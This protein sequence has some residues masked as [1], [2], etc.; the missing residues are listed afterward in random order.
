MIVGTASIVGNSCGLGA[1]LISLVFGFSYPLICFRAWDLRAVSEM[2][3]PRSLHQSSKYFHPV[4][5]IINLSISSLKSL[6]QVLHFLNVLNNLTVNIYDNQIPNHAYYW[7]YL[8]DTFSY[9]LHM[10]WWFLNYFFTVLKLEP[11]IFC[12]K[13]DVIKIRSFGSEEFT[14]CS[15][16]VSITNLILYSAIPFKFEVLNSS[17]GML[18]K[19]VSWIL[20][21]YLTLCINPSLAIASLSMLSHIKSDRSSTLDN[22]DTSI[23][24]NASSQFDSKSS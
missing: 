9:G 24:N 2:I 13:L 23:N 16:I 15:L 14:L 10:S 22:L 18:S 7:S 11:D 1:S 19:F 21:R 12:T 6:W 4:P 8:A 20:L 17:R 5:D 3:E